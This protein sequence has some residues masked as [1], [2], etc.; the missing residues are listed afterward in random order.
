MQGLC[1]PFRG[2]SRSGVTISTA[3]IQ[4][5][6][7]PIAEDFSFALAVVLTPPAMVWELRR[8]VRSKE[9]ASGGLAQLV[10]PGTLGMFFSL[11][12]GLLALRLLS[13]LLE[14][15]QWKY[16][17]YYCIAAALVVFGLYACGL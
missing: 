6:A 9:M 10:M 3:L 11:A 17:G 12:C 13:A 4:G 1:I 7:R 14:R 5:A 16:F 8:L 2:F 15:G